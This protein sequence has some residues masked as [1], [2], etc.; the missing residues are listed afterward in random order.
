MG[1]SDDSDVD[2]L[3][4]NSLVD[5]FNSAVKVMPVRGVVRRCH[6]SLGDGR[7]AAPP[8]YSEGVLRETDREP[9]ILFT[10]FL[11]AVYRHGG[12]RRHYSECRLAG[13][14]GDFRRTLHVCKSRC[15][16]VV[17]IAE[18]LGRSLEFQATGSLAKNVEFNGFEEL[19]KEVALAY[20]AAGRIEKV[21]KTWIEEMAKENH[22]LAGRDGRSSLRYSAHALALQTF[23]GEAT[24]PNVE[25]TTPPRRVR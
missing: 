3:I 17:T 22:L 11:L 21:V 8:A 19:R 12:P 10:P 23:I 6:H 18:Q 1:T 25:Q 14:S 7:S 16:Q 4:S 2:Q 15:V 20:M 5:D 24:I 9:T 13:M